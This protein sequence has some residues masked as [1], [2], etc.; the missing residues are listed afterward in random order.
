MLVVMAHRGEQVG[1]VVVVKR[2]ADVPAITAGPNESQRAQN[3]EVVRGR[4]EA[5]LC[6]RGKLL[7]SALAGQ[8]IG[9]DTQP[10]R[11][12]QGLERL[13]QLIGLVMAQGAGDGT[14]LGW[15]RHSVEGTPYEQVLKCHRRAAVAAM[16]ASLAAP[17][18][19]F[20]H[21][22][23]GGYDPGRSALEYVWL[24]FWHMLAGWDHLLFLAGILLLAGSVRTAAKLI[25]C[26]SSG[27]ASHC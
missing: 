3:T 14:V 9:E 18:A 17:T 24:G 27:T 26:S 22:L 1:D 13:G 21:G 7:N 19:S 2:V 25:R 11:R 6:G 23:A 10:R 5:Q 8:Q 20:A 15:M 16:L 4:A 12:A